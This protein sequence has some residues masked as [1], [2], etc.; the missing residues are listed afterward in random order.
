MKLLGRTSPEMTIAF[1][2]FCI[3][4]GLSF[5]G[6][7][8]P[9]SRCYALDEDGKESHSEEVVEPMGLDPS[10]P[11]TGP[12]RPKTVKNGLLLRG[13]QVIVAHWRLVVSLLILAVFVPFV[14]LLLEL[15]VF[16][17]LIGFAL[18]LMF[19][20][21]QVFWI[22]RVLDLGQRFMPGKPGRAR[23]AIVTG[24]VY[25]FFL[26]YWVSRGLPGHHARAADF[27]L[28]G[29][30]AWWVVGSQLAFLLVIAFGT[31]D[32][33]A[34]A[35]GWLYRKA[36]ETILGHGAA[37]RSRADPS[38]PGRRRFLEQTAVLVSATPFVAVGYGLLYER[39]DVEVVRQRIRLPRLPRAFEGFR[40]AQLSDFHFSPFTPAG[41]IRRCVTM[42]NGLKPDLVVMT[43]DY[44]DSD[45]APQQEV[46]EVLAR[47]RAPCGV[48]GCLGNHEPITHTEESITRLFAAQGIRIL[49]QESAPIRVGGEMLN[50]IGMD[51]PLSLSDGN[52]CLQQVKG[53]V[54]PETVNI[55]LV[56]FPYVFDRAAEFGM[57][58]VLAGHT[59]GGQLCFVTPNISFS[60]LETR[61]VSGWY[62]KGGAQLYVNRGIG[63]IDPNIRLGARPEI[64]LLELTRP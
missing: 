55:L 59:H 54:M 18:L 32:R 60:R 39:L 14:K 8:R 41:Y 9:T 37:P 61:Y 48:F 34:R 53:L 50:L 15:N 51:S 30:F 2:E 38:S 1:L 3:R 24:P 6:C 21:S 52:R 17:V 12:V 33:A 26:G 64:T 62:E 29:T 5:R 7:A 13:H 47:L 10:S 45:A 20:A 28:V 36:C 56:H 63:T 49:R 23:L 43:G 19:I 27:L 31:A 25:L 58:L 40:I 22:G 42:T 4:K 35:A 44:L 57:D 16:F 46:V 11:F